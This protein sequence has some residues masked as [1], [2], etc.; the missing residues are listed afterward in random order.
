MFVS[1]AR[2][3]TQQSRLAITL[4]WVAG[5]TNILTLITCGTAT[6]HVSGTLSQ[7]GL[8]LVEG[9]WSLMAFTS[10][11]LG[12]F[13]VGAVISGVCTEVGRRRG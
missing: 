5:Y 8:D 7:W 6:S 4:A 9:K 10:L 11:V 1:Q 12:C 13:F 3:I 2:S